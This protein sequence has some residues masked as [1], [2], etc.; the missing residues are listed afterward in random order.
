MGLVAPEASVLAMQTPVSPV[1]S[2]G[3]ASVCLCPSLFSQGHQSCSIRVHPSD[4]TSTSG[5]TL[6]PNIGTLGVRAS[7]CD[8]RVTIHSITDPHSF[9]LDTD[10][11]LRASH[12]RGPL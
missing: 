12:L 8:F 6:P 9:I 11:G 10:L 4:F 5:K 2:C 3:C 7:M 1:S